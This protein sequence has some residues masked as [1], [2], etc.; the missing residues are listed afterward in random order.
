VRG[1][2]PSLMLFFLPQKYV[3]MLKRDAPLWD[4]VY[5]GFKTAANLPKVE[6]S[7]Q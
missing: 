6:E 5:V 4:V 1:C 2:R 3:Q 7:G